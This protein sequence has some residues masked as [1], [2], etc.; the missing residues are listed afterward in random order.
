MSQAT[1]PVL[2]TNRPGKQP[3][4]DGFR[5]SLG[6][7]REQ[8]GGAAAL[9]QHLVHRLHDLR[10]PLG[11]E[12][13]EGYPLVPGLSHQQQQGQAV[14]NQHRDQDSPGGETGPGSARRSTAAP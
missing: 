14:Q 12:G 4:Q 2:V 9:P 6:D 1:R 5:L 8:R 10:A 7:P 13:L 3:L 11:Q